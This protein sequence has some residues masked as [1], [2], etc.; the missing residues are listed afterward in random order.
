MEGP[1]LDSRFRQI[2]F[3]FDEVTIGLNFVRSAEHMTDPSLRART[4]SFA[5]RTHNTVRR[6]MPAAPLTADERTR[7]TK[8]LHE[9]QERIDDRLDALV[10]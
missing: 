3:L 7:L 5:Q 10:E 8:S 6:L 9:L 2:R 1:R 4:L